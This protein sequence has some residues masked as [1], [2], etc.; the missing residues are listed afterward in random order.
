MYKVENQQYGASVVDTY[1][2]YWDPKPWPTVFSIHGGGWVF[3][4]EDSGPTLEHAKKLVEHGYMVVSIRY[5]LA[6]DNENIWPTQY[7]DVA[8][9]IN[10]I[11]TGQYRKYIGKCG[12]I[13]SSAGAHIASMLTLTKLFL[14]SVLLYGP[15][16]LEQWLID[17]NEVA[18][19]YLQQAFT[20]EMYA[21]ESPARRIGGK[22]PETLLIHGK[23]D[24]LV[25]YQQSIDFQKK[26]GEKAELLLVDGAEHSLQGNN[27]NPSMEDVDSKILGFFNRTLR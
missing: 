20:P 13:G 7:Q 18:D 1:M 4:D 17:D 25:N 6:K 27:L 16:D 15:Y 12:L 22:I 5:R 19:T 3:G 10:F 11:R 24:S 23:N 8:E 26:L 14:P 9:A 21:H 2:P